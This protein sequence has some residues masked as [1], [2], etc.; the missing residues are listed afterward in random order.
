[1]NAYNNLHRWSEKKPKK[2]FSALKLLSR[3]IMFAA[4]R[5]WTRRL[6]RLAFKLFKI[7][8]D[9]A[10]RS[11]DGVIYANSVDRLAAAL[12]W[13]HSLLSGF[14]SEIYKSAVKKGA[15]VLE[16]G[17]NIGFFTTLFAKLA[18]ESGK[19]VAFEPDPDNFRLLEKNIQANDCKNAVCVQKAVSDRTGTGRLYLCE[20]HRGDHRLFDSR[21]GRRSVEVETAAIDDFMPGGAVVNFI[22]MDIQ[23][24]EYLA[25]Q[26]M[27][28]TI[29]NS[30]HLLML[31]EFSPALLRRAGTDPLEFL[32][33]LEALGF[34][35]KYLDEEKKSAVPA[36][37]AELLGKCEGE[38]YLNLYLE[39]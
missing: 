36:G 27:E 20:E 33:K 2:I 30:G 16:I 23:G 22:K 26:G 5:D 17:A 4:S 29:K 10:V 15:T 6:V 12:L 31:C 39:K 9:I 21:D 19:V 34:T 32:K 3:L 13:K 24:A 8:R 1:M 28:R 37:T 14:E 7:N 38:D 11:G 25:L 35:L 18:G